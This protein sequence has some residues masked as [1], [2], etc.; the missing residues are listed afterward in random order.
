MLIAGTETS[1]MT[2]EAAGS[3][4]VSNPHVLKKARDKIDANVEQ[5]RLLDD[6][7]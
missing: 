7:D 5:S 4:F 6:A 2:V 1:A 3:F